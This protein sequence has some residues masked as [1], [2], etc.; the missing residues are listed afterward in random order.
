[1]IKERFDRSDKQFDEVTEKMRATN[2]RFAELEHEA[3][4]PRLAMEGDVTPGTKIRKRTENAAVDQVMNGSKSSS[5]RVDLDPMCLTSF[6]D[7]SIELPAVPCGV[8]TLG[9]KGTEAPKPCLSPVEMRTLI[10][11][12]SLLPAGTA[13]TATRTIF[14]RPLCC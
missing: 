6:D 11:T 12:G 14:P 2:P 4:Q 13:S 9:D 8:D 7:D 1:M 10:A 3:R 5:V